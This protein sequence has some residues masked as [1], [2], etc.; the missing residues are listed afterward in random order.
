MKQ[1]GNKFSNRT[2]D[3]RSRDAREDVVECVYVREARARATC[4]WTGTM[5]LT[6]GIIAVNEGR[7][8]ERVTESVAAQKVSVMAI[9]KS[10]K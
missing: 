1:G 8:Q 2:G 6:G 4:V 3:E 5:M 7:L 9:E 10:E